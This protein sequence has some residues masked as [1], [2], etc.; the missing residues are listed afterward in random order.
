MKTFTLNDRQMELVK[1]AISNRMS[2]L[3]D[4]LSELL[5]IRLLFDETPANCVEPNKEEEK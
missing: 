5:K 4:E 3:T 1:S 2:D